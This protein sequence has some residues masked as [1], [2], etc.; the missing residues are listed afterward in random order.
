MI[1]TAIQRGSSVYVYNER[2][3]QIFVKSGELHGY[4]S[5]TVSVKNGHSIYT[6]NEKGSQ[7]SVHSC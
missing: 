1:G 2:N 3:S 6:Y 7:I 4:T 5:S